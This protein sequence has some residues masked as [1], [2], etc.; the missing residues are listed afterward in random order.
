V[1]NNFDHVWVAEGDK[2]VDRWPITAR[3]AVT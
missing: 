2:V 3:G 1:V